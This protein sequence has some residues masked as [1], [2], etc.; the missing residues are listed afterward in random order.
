MLMAFPRHIQNEAKDYILLGHLYLL[1]HKWITSIDVTT[2]SA[3][4]SHG[5]RI[6]CIH[7]NTNLNCAT[8]VFNCIFQELF[9]FDG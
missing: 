7:T 4:A 3:S 1:V 9:L 5:V 2:R 6:C 8:T